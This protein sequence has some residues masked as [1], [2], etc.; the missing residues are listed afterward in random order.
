MD[1]RHILQILYANVDKIEQALD[2][3]QDIAEEIEDVELTGLIEEWI[4]NITETL[5][6]NSG[7]CLE[8][9]TE[10]IEENYDE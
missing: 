7:T 3:I 2:E 4:N 5:N 8:S 10:Y 6:D 9:I 1:K